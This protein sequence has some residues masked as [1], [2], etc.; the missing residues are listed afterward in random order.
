MKSNITSKYKSAC[1]VTVRLKRAVADLAKTC[2]LMDENIETEKSTIITYRTS[3]MKIFQLTVDMF[4]Q[5]IKEL[6]KQSYGTKVTYPKSIFRELLK[7][8]L[9]ENEQV[10]KLSAMVT[11]RNRI[12]HT[13]SEDIAITISYAIPQ[14]Y[15]LINS[16]L[17]ALAPQEQLV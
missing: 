1:K 9:I 7:N 2:T 8:N 12:V 16:T 14:H 3:L 6:L 11:Y 4:L 5:Y 10:E 17:T 13:Y 15:E